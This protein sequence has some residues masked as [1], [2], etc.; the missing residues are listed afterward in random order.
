MID[1]EKFKPAKAIPRGVDTALQHDT[2]KKMLLKG[3]ET[4]ENGEG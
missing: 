1:G 3:L 2:E 4:G